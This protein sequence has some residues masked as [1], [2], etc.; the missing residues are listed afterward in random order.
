[1]PIGVGG[2]IDIIN[3]DW[4]DIVT[5]KI[6]V[7]DSV[8]V[9][10]EGNLVGRLGRKGTVITVDEHDNMINVKF[11]SK[12]LDTNEFTWWYYLDEPRYSSKGGIQESAACLDFIGS[13]GGA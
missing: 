11:D 3:D 13:G 12:A 7:G 2:I 1:M 9:I 4:T 6:R 5:R 8:V 10:N